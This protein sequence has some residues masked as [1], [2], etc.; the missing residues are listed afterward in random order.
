MANQEKKFIK[1]PQ[2]ND[3]VNEVYDKMYKAAKEDKEHYFDELA[4]DIYWHTKY[5]KVSFSIS[6]LTKRVGVGQE[7][8]SLVQMVS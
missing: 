8:G 7:Q 5:T 6:F 1:Y 2:S 4:G 3:F